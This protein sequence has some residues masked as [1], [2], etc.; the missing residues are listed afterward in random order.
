[1][2]RIGGTMLDEWAKHFLKF[3][4]DNKSLAAELAK[5]SLK[6]AK[7]LWDVLEKRDKAMEVHEKKL[8]TAAIAT[9]EAGVT[10]KKLAE[11]MKDKDFAAAK[12]ALDEDCKHLEAELSA[13]EDYCDKCRAAAEKAYV[14]AQ[15]MAKA[16]IAD[17]TKE[18]HPER[19]K[20]E[21]LREA[22]MTRFE[23]L[24]KAEKMRHKPPKYLMVFKKQY[25][26]LIDHLIAEALKKGK[27][28]EDQLE[29][30]QPL[31]DKK[32]GALV[33]E[34]ARLVGS[35]N[36]SILKKE[37]IEAKA[38]KDQKPPAPGAPETPKVP[39]PA[40]EAF[41]AKA[42]RTFG[43]LQ[44]I[45]EEAESLKAKFKAE[46][47]LLKEKTEILKQFKTIEQELERAQT[48][49]E[50]GTVKAKKVV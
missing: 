46:I 7:D 13:L 29:V 30:P 36:T 35:I 37:E 50:E 11:F 25:D 17:T 45:A 33:K 23:D 20:V 42:K 1:M 39:D 12:A 41:L 10:S 49:I 40:A 6:D 28:P 34:A 3:S 31:T 19:E 5:Y 43:K 8:G 47:A 18:K 15:K 14:L 16:L 26:K 48:C 9:Y 2:R 22:L 27:D 21:K 24:S 4:A 32:L 38:K 44:K